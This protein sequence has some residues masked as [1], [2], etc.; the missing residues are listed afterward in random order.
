MR[1]VRSEPAS[2][3]MSAPK[4]AVKASELP[5]RL[6]QR[7]GLQFENE[8]LLIEALTHPSFVGEGEANRL[9]S[10]QRLEFLGDSVL[11]LVVSEYIFRRHPELAEG[12]LTKIKAVAVSEGAL[13]QAAREL[14]L[15]DYL[16]LGKGEEASGGR[17]RPSI[18]AD[19]F[20]ALIGA[21][22]LQHGIE[23]ARAFVLRV[24]SDSIAVI[25]SH[26]HVPDY[27]SLLQE[28][29]Q[30]E[31]RGTPTYHVLETSGPDHNKRFTVEVRARQAVLG[32]GTGANKKEAEQSA[33]GDALAAFTTSAEKPPAS[34]KKRGRRTAEAEQLLGEAAAETP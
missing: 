17:S 11:G 14:K 25:E 28:L 18:L 31:G 15:G 24:L 3:P 20:E 4:A 21:I 8:E 29:V 7:L 33:A 26:K 30:A 10:N 6:Q 34:R 22:F 16:L 13:V 19:A 1:V 23:A 5:A 27:K 2:V 9:Q 12:S 32:H